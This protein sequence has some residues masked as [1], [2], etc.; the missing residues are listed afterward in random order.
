M[1][2]NSKKT[3]IAGVHRVKKKLSCGG[4]RTYHYVFRG[5][6]K[7]WSDVC[8]YDEADPQYVLDY[9]AAL[10]GTRVKS[11]ISGEATTYYIDRYRSSA[12]YKRLKPRTQSDYEKYL[13]SFEEE[14]GVD[15]IKM[16]E[17]MEA[18]G[19]IRE[20]RSKWSHSPKQ[21]D[22]AGS[23]ITTFLTWCV[24]ADSAITVHYH[25]DQKKLY[26]SN[27][28]QIIWLPSEIEMLL[29]EARPQ[30]VPIVIAFSE[31]G[32]APQDVG[33][34]KREH[35]QMT[36]KGRRLY[37]RRQKTEN[38]VGLPVTEAL[39]LL[40]DNLP[41]DQELLVTSLTGGPLKALRASQVIRDIKV[42]HNAKVDAGLLP[43]RIRDELRPYDM[44]G[45]AATALLRAGCSLNEIAVTMGWGLRHASNVI[46]RYAAL[47][48]EVTDEVH[49]KLVKAKRK[50]AK[51]ERKK[52]K[53]AKK[54]S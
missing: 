35:V 9:Q 51:L 2:S 11:K 7:F 42:R 23:V 17:E 25:K 21:Y 16:F 6:P 26:S 52:S 5:G 18:V 40:I 46:E 33:F 14:F 44:R 37:F 27:R 41:E 13:K 50:A 10:T 49:K 1:V 8:D 29:N 22:Y 47:V 15:P 36:P 34:L 30:E 31:G 3:R 53:K 43:I 45:T 12:E 20:W 4:L 39:G 32:L 54:P 24:E 28:S 19:Q 38:A 48:P